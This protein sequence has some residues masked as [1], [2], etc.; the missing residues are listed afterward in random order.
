MPND[1]APRVAVGQTAIAGETVIAEFS[2][3]AI[4]PLVRVS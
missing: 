2:A 4:A 3:G 1:A